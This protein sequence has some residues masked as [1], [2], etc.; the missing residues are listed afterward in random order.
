MVDSGNSCNRLYET[1][2]VFAYKTTAIICKWN[3]TIYLNLLQFCNNLLNRPNCFCT[4]FVNFHSVDTLLELLFHNLNVVVNPNKISSIVSHGMYRRLHFKKN[5][6]TYTVRQTKHLD[7]CPLATGRLNR[8]LSDHI[9]TA[10]ATGWF[11][12]V[13]S[14]PRHMAIGRRADTYPPVAGRI[15]AHRSQAGSTQPSPTS[16]Q[17]NRRR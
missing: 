17:F 4:V 13:R 12:R 1:I 3:A 9:Q 8:A 2:P 16:G 11:N 14:A 7:T 10:T 6:T 5:F 15:H